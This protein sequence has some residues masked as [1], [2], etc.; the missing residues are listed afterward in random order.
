MGA[1]RELPAD[2]VLRLG[3]CREDRK[4]LSLLCGGELLQLVSVLQQIF[5]V[6]QVKITS[7]HLWTS[8]DECC[9]NCFR[10]RPCQDR[11]LREAWER[12]SQDR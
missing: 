1:L 3:M 12:C 4:L 2:D 10:M 5:T 9:R 6:T 8:S 7:K 11:T